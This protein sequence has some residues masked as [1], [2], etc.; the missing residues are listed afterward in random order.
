MLNSLD[1]KII[2]DIIR[3][4]VKNW[5]NALPFWEAHFSIKPGMHVLVLGDREGGLS[6]YF[7]LKGCIVT[8]T[9]LK[10]PLDEAKIIHQKYGLSE[11]ITYEK[12]DMSRLQ[13]HDAQ[14]DIVAFKS[15]I[16]AL[17]ESEAQAGA[18][19]EMKRVL[20]TGGAILF[21]ENSNG[22]LLHKI[23]RRK[24]VKWSKYWKYNSDKDFSNWQKEFSSGH[25][26]K[27]GFFG[28]FGRS[29]KQRNVLGSIDATFGRMFPLSWRYICFGLFIK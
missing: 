26:K 11:V 1:K 16:G 18:I 22:S 24:F 27:F 12:A 5:K 20:K 17:T 9:E 8:C 3:W 21:A 10:S 2:H 14:F 23:L 7:A 15:V 6:L 29:E 28:L 4:D 25:L 13:Y 19:L